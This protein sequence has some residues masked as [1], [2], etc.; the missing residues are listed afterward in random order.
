[1]VLFSGQWV[2]TVVCAPTVITVESS[3]SRQS[4]IFFML[5]SY[6]ISIFRPFFRMMPL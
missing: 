5:F 6:F 3:A 2:V 4:V 1:M